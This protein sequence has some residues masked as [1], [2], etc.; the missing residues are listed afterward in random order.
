M[1]EFKIRDVKLEDV[2]DLIGLCV[3]P[4]K[5]DDPL[6]VEGMKAKRRWASRLIEMYGSIAKLAYLGSRPVGMIQYRPLP[7][8]RLIEITC[9]FVPGKE[10]QRKGIGRSLLEALIDSARGPKGYLGGNAPLALITWAFEV[11]GLFPQHEFYRKMGFRRV[12]DPFLLYYPL[13]EGYAYSPREKK[14][15]PLEEDMGRALVFFDPS[16]PFSVYFAEKFRELIGEAAPDI[17]IRVIN[18]F[19]EAE[20]VDRRGGRSP[21]LRY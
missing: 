17:P 3:P 14:F 9:I 2:D 4:D 11:P 6:F 18:T 15:T 16:C 5:R 20:E 1:V 7:D 10:N 21:L 12:S 13:K 8:E 19:E